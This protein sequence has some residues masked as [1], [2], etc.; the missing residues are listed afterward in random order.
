[1]SDYAPYVVSH[2]IQYPQ[3]RSS[4]SI[5]SKALLLDFVGGWFIII[6]MVFAGSAA[7][8]GDI[9]GLNTTTD[10]S[11]FSSL[12]I[13]LILFAIAVPIVEELLFRGLILDGLSETYGSWTAIFISSAIFAILHISPLSIINAFWGG[14]IYGYLRIRTNSL[15]PG[16]LL[17][18]LWNGHLELLNFFYFV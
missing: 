6:F 7:S 11:D 14:M 13:A 16:I 5:T 17:H 8:I 15:W 9:F 1:M 3:S 18:A 12:V 4:V 10:L 2:L